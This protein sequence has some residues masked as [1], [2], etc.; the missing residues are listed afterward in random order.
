MKCHL[1]P[2][3][4]AWSLQPDLC[5]RTVV[6]T[7]Q[8]IFVPTDVA[9]LRSVLPSTTED[10]FFDYLATL[11]TSEVT[12]TAVPE[13][14]VV[15]ARV[16]RAQYPPPLQGGRGRHRPVVPAGPIP[17][18]EGATAGGAAAGDHVVVSGQL[19]QVGDTLCS[20]PPV[21]GVH[22]H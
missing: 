17:A 9:Y 8:L 12:V 2:V 3:W 1:S 6:G 7:P 18:G 15:F 11:D 20:G 10:A 22:I 19:R 21:T 13:G 5:H 14:S 4:E 16:G